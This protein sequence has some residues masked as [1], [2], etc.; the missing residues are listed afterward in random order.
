MLRLVYTA[1]LVLVAVSGAGVK[2]YGLA[3]QIG[4]Y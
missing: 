2:I 4:A 1:Y 3:L